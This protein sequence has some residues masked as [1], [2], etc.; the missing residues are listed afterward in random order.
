[1]TSETCYT[2]RRIH[3]PCGSHS[4]VLFH[5]RSHLPAR[6]RRPK[7]GRYSLGVEFA[8]ST[9]RTGLAHVLTSSELWH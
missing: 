3:S 5:L 9:S 4:T 7:L 8:D 6:V 1:M 2:I